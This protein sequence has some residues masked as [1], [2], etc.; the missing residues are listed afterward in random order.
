[1]VIMSTTVFTFSKPCTSYIQIFLPINILRT[2]SD[3]FQLLYFSTVR[4][5]SFEMSC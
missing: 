1:M 5:E 4:A 3:Y 2:Y